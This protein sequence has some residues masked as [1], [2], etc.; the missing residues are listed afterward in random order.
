MSFR[1]AYGQIEDG[2]E[3][4]TGLQ[5]LVG[6]PGTGKT[7]LLACLESRLGDR[8]RVLR[9]NFT[10]FSESDFIEKLAEGLGSEAQQADPDAAAAALA[11]VL[12]R[13]AAGPRGLL[14]LIDDA[15][16]LGRATLESLPD[17][18]SLGDAARPARAQIVLAACPDFEQ[19]LLDSGLEPL[20]ASVDRTCRLEPLDE[21]EIREYILDAMAAAGYRGEP[22]FADE[23]IARIAERSAGV[24]RRINN[25]C[26]VALLAAYENGVHCVG[27]DMVD[28]GAATLLSEA[29]D[30][31]PAAL[32]EMS[33]GPDAG[34]PGA[35]PGA[36]AGGPSADLMDR[37]MGG[38]R[39]LRDEG[40]RRFAAA[41]GR[42]GHPAL[43]PELRDWVAGV[44]RSIGLGALVLA[45]VAVVVAVLP[46]PQER[47]ELAAAPEKP[48]DDQAAEAGAQIAA[49]ERAL[50][51]AATERHELRATIRALAGSLA[52]V[53]TRMQSALSVSPTPSGAAPQPPSADV[54]PSPP[55][56]EAPRV[57]ASPSAT[58]A[59][60]AR[61]AE[62]AARPAPAPRAVPASAD[63]EA[64]AAEPSRP[65]ETGPGPAPAARYLVVNKGDTLWTIA[66]QHGLSVA[67][68]SRTNRL[69]PSKPL[70]PG[71]RLK[72][73]AGAPGG[74]GAAKSP[75]WYTV[76]RGDSL[77]SIG[78][79]FDVPVETLTRWNRLDAPD[80]LQ[81]GQRLLVAR[82]EGRP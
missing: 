20:W 35:R 2:V 5:L 64:A 55:A 82:A 80:A 8:Y 73:P 29:A 12:E 69:S 40:R 42:F 46:W 23:A 56:P 72:V 44:W 33:A 26:G 30:R 49:L 7:R 37:A 65:A 58:G 57:A 36:T 39:T 71:Q 81:P 79:R 68:L 31:E 67:E 60:A 45:L 34:A 4:G 76:R 78:R 38:I 70:Y 17:I 52:Q 61:P 16:R 22:V 62:D 43:P 59:V 14:L 50:Q 6:P 27:A 25:L 63:T 74:A 28:E 11:M 19:H 32:S 53:E 10:G 18:F 1:T 47:P 15:E 77:S 54:V 51:Q 66:R 3:A 75:E 48:M 24:P 21:E 13:E 41:R 9:P